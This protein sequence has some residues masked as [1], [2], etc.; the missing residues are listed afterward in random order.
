[1]AQVDA[2]GSR[3]A[4]S[5]LITYAIA[6]VGTTLTARD[7]VNSGLVL[8]FRSAAPRWPLLGCRGQ[9]SA[10]CSGAAA[11]RWRVHRWELRARLGLSVEL[12]LRRFGGADRLRADGTNRTGRHQ[13]QAAVRRW[14]IAIDLPATPAP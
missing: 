2:V 7:A 4:V 13:H 12:L 8:A 3:H 1:M 14:I 10:V 9:R 11:D 6:H 5:S